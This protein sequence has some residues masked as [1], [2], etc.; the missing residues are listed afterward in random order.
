MNS[1]KLFSLLPA[2]VLSSCATQEPV[3][4]CGWVV[5]IRPS[6][7]EVSQTLSSSTLRQIAAANAAIKANCPM[8]YQTW[9][10]NLPSWE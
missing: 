2:L 5:P 1:N 3:D 7:E 9:K 4:A 8:R 6:R 10:K